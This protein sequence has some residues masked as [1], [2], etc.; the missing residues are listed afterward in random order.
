MVERLIWRLAIRSHITEIHTVFAL[1][2]LLKQRGK[3][4]HLKKEPVV[5]VDIHRKAP[6]KTKANNVLIV[7]TTQM[8]IPLPLTM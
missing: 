7:G 8:P 3:K 6:E 4:C 1:G 2:A 5:K